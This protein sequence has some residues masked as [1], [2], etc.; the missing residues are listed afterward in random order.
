MINADTA[1]RKL[2]GADVSGNDSATRMTA[3]TCSTV[4]DVQ[5]HSITI[6]DLTWNKIPLKIAEGIDAQLT[7]L[8]PSPDDTNPGFVK[9]AGP[10]R[11]NDNSNTNANSG[12]TRKKDK[13]KGAGSRNSKSSR[14]LAQQ[15][16]PPQLRSHLH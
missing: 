12:K 13:L 8:L 15:P 11:D 1:V 7:S 10:M 5:K 3:M 14:L 16:P 9:A 2:A 6:A 4:T